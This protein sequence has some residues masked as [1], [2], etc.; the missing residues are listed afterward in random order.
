VL[1]T[2]TV[3]FTASNAR[4]QSAFSLSVSGRWNWMPLL[5]GTEHEKREWNVVQGERVEM[6]PW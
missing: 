6:S 4:C 5:G 2:P 3:G 1:S